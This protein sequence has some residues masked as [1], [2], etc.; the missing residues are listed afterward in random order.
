MKPQ[1][2][3][4]FSHLNQGRFSG[5]VI[6]IRN[7]L[8]SPEGMANFPEPW[9]DP[10]KFPQRAEL[11]AAIDA[12]LPLYAGAE[13]GSRSMIAA[14]NASRER[15]TAMLQKVAPCLETAAGYDRG[16]LGTTGF[17]LRKGSPTKTMPAMLL[18]GPQNVRAIQG[19]ASGKI[20]VSSKSVSGAR[21]YEVQV[22][23]G[24]RTKEADF[25]HGASSSGCT[26][27]QIAGLTP[28]KN[29]A[30]RMRAL[31]GKRGPGAWSELPLFPVL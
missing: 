21:A 3:T 14:R 28:L 27:I 30:I 1:L 29:Y 9:G 5:Q 2:K 7:A 23:G 4:K 26:N 16:K 11:F 6:V 19:N 10:A 15:I 25:R 18:T 22:N 12:H 8:S 20:R 24:D 31:F 13:D 17:E